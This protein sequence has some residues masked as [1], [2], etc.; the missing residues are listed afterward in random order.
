MFKRKIE[1]AMPRSLNESQPF[2]LPDYFIRAFLD[3]KFV[4]FHHDVRI[5][6]DFVLTAAL[7]PLFILDFM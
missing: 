5:F 2:Q 1:T 6:G 4:G 3:G 7:Y